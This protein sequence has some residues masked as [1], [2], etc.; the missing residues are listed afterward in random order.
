MKK[1]E[2]LKIEGK[3]KLQ[4]IFFPVEWKKSIIKY[5]K[6]AS[7]WV[8]DIEQ[9]L[10][11]LIIINVMTNGHLHYL[12]INKNNNNDNHNSNNERAFMLSPMPCCLK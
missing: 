8:F 4:L 1:I 12:N 3:G 5:M 10:L 7:A 11:L 6:K 9:K 2:Q